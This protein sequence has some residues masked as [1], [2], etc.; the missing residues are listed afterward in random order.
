MHAYGTNGII[1]EVEM[2]LTRVLR[3]GRR[4]RRL[5]RLHGRGALR[6]RRSPCQDGLL[7]KQITPVAA[8]VAVRLFPAPPE[9]PAARAERRA[10]CM[11]A[12][13]A[14]DAFLAFTAARRRR[15]RLPRRLA[16]DAEK[17]GLPP[18]YELTWNHTTLR[19]APRRSDHHLSAGAL[20][21]P[22]HLDAASRRWTKMFRRRGA[23]AS[24]IHALR[25][26]HHLLRPAAGALHDARSGSTR[27]S[28]S[29][30]TM[31]ARSST[32]T[33]TRWRKAA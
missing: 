33:A 10:C 32:R 7:S 19:G 1:T 30:R 15:D 28:A 24:R 23:R 4:H 18:V 2:P 8:P 22:D 29:T 11:I 5:R 16:T 31:A 9:I 27:S 26:Q 14:M 17:K 3:L 13:H 12:P 21:L 25:R 20:S 6:Q